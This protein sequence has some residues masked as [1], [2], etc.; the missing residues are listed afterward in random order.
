[1]PEEKFPEWYSYLKK[2]HPNYMDA[3]QKLG[4]VVREQ[5]PLDEKTI[6]L[7][8]LAAAT[9]IYSEGAVHSHAKRAMEA[10]ASR[11]EIFHAVMLLTSTLGFP[12]VSAALSWVNDVMESGAVRS[13]KRDL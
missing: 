5:G 10:G 3:V 12:R 4:R 8:Q 6:N 7:I 9:A 13:R 2:K 11:E 1:M